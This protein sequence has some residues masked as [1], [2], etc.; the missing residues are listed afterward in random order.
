MQTMNCAVDLSAL[1]RARVQDDPWP[2]ATYSGVF[3]PDVVEAPFPHD[4]F[5][6]HSQRRILDA[7]GKEGSDAWHQHNVRTRPLLELGRSEPYEHET[8]D[9]AWLAVARDL[10]SPEFRDCLSDV[11]LHDVRNL[12]MQAHFWEFSEGSFFQP[13]IDKPHKIVTILMYL[14]RGWQEADGGRLQILGS[15]DPDDVRHSVPPAANI[16]V[17]LRRTSEAWHSVSP[18]PFGTP[19]PRRLL[20][21]WFWES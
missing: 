9:P 3:A 17:V 18:I 21:A 1:G 5:S 11:V 10:A 6:Y 12:E 2:W 13:H 16:G 20:Q 8:L 14:T 4:H 7:I 19:R 15:S